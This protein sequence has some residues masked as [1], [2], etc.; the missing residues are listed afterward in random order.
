MKNTS[1]RSFIARVRASLPDLHPSEHRLAEAVLNFPGDMAGYSASE[2]ASLAGV[3]NATVSRFVR[4]IGYGSYEEARKAVRD[5]GRT[6]T[7]LLRF[8]AGD[9]SGGTALASHLEQS[10]LN[11]EKTFEE[12]DAGAVDELVKAMHSASRVWLAGFRAGYPLANYLSWQVCQ[13]LTQVTLIPR[14]GETLAETAA[15]F[16]PK[17][18]LVLIAL[19]RAP[20]HAASL[21]E[22]AIDAGTK[23]AFIGDIPKIEALQVSWRF[24]CATTSSGPLLNHTGVLAVCNMIAARIVERSGA[25]GRNRL[26]RIEDI[27]DRFAEL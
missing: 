27:H 3:S 9:K 2:I 24:R 10:R 8:A 6:G 18:V 21:V 15:S 22:A 26:G 5:E 23:I 11:L 25:R 13:V 17:D 12:L 19:R 20:K 7:A 14:P 1:T 16:D 4:K